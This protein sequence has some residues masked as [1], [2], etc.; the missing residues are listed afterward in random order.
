T[1]AESRQLLGTVEVVP[2]TEVS[3]PKAAIQ[4]AL[5]DA[6]EKLGRERKYAPDG[7]ERVADDLSADLGLA[8]FVPHADLRGWAN[9]GQQQLA[10][11]INNGFKG[12]TSI[13]DPSKD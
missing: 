1:K 13:N 6:A 5:V 4:K 10:F 11:T 2:G 3:D 12:G 7:A 8:S 9:V